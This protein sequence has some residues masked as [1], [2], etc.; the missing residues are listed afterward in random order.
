MNQYIWI[1]I[2]PSK[3]WNF[4]K[5][6]RNHFRKKN[7]CYWGKK[8]RRNSIGSISSRREFVGF[9]RKL[10]RKHLLPATFTVA[11]TPFS[12]RGFYSLIAGAHIAQN[13]VVHAM[14]LFGK[15]FR[16]FFNQT[17][18]PGG[19]SIALISINLWYRTSDRGLHVE[20]GIS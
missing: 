2:F 6:L 17:H 7:W 1:K 12:I 4:K 19:G 9:E 5:V 8:L 20:D 14:L 18:Q 11:A 3:T 15:W 13:G 10:S 16:A